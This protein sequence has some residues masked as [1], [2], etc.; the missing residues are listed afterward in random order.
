MKTGSGNLIKSRK[1][2]LVINLIVQEVIVGDIIPLLI[3]DCYEETNTKYDGSVCIL[4]NHEKGLFF[5]IFDRQEIIYNYRSHRFTAGNR[6]KGYNAS[7]LCLGTR[8][9]LHS[10]LCMGNRIK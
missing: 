2:V 5:R 3:E 8:Y 9:L 10:M 1:R 6:H 4:Q 7:Q